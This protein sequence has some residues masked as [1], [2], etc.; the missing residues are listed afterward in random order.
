[1]VDTHTHKKKKAA[2]S[3][4]PVAF[5]FCYLARVVTVQEIKGTNNRK[6]ECM[7]L[8]ILALILLDFH[9]APPPKQS[10]LLSPG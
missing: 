10:K 3:F 5:V 8:V 7:P 1:M 4:P 6:N 2:Q 9:S